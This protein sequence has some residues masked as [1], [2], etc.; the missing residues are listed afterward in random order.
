MKQP[1]FERQRFLMRRTGMP[2]LANDRL[3]G[4]SR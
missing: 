4:D 1:V 2:T 3:T